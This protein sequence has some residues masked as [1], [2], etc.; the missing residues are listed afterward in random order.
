MRSATIW[1]RDKSGQ[2][3]ILVHG[4]LLTNLLS[5]NLKPPGYRPSLIRTEYTDENHEI[6]KWSVGKINKD[7]GKI[8]E[9]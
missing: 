2:R 6:L 7:Y 5:G 3:A 8:I 4:A 1:R 9:H